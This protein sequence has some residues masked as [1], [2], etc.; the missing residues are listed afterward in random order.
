MDS[1]AVRLNG[2]RSDELL[3]LAF[4]LQNQNQ[5]IESKN[6]NENQNENE[7]ENEDRFSRQNM[8]EYTKCDLLEWLEKGYETHPNRRHLVQALKTH[9]VISQFVCLCLCL[10]LFLCIYIYIYIYLS[11]YT[12]SQSF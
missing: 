9:Q 11:I 10:S 8:V 4:S 5:K 1:T 3:K 6:E 2:R 12:L 7:N